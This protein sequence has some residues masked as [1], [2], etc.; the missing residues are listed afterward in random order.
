MFFKNLYQRATYPSLHTAQFTS[1]LIHFFLFC[2]V[3]SAPNATTHARVV[4]PVASQPRAAP[5][6][7]DPRATRPHGSPAPDIV[8]P[9][10]GR[11]WPALRQR[12]RPQPTQA[13]SRLCRRPR[14]TRPGHSPSRKPDAT[15]PLLPNTTTI[16]SPS[17]EVSSLKSTNLPQMA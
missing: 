12:R 1:T 6:A 9:I 15:G 11:C 17:G 7:V 3:A 10:P 8:V 14:P 16:A 5:T 4:V 2:T 13:A